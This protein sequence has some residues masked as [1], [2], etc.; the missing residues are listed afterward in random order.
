MEYSRLFQRTVLVLIT[1]TAFSILYG[2]FVV[3]VLEPPMP[4]NLQQ[5]P[6]SARPRMP[7]VSDPQYRGLFHE[8]D[9][10]Q[11]PDALLRLNRCHIFLRGISFSA[12]QIQGNECTIL[13][14]PKAN[15]ETEGTSISAPLLIHVPEGIELRFEPTDPNAMELGP[16][17]WAHIKGTIEGSCA[18]DPTTPNDDVT[19]SLK[20]VFYENGFISTDDEIDFTMGQMHCKGQGLRLPLNLGNLKNKDEA[21][22]SLPT[23]TA[24][25]FIEISKLECL[26]VLLTR[27]MLAASQQ[28]ARPS[29]TSATSSTS[30]ETNAATTPTA[31]GTNALAAQETT[32]RDSQSELPQSLEGLF[33]EDG[34]LPAG[35]RCQ[36]NVL[37]DLEQ[38]KM[39]FSENVHIYVH[40]GTGV[41]DSLDCDTLEI[42]FHQPQDWTESDHL[43]TE[44]TRTVANS[45]IAGTTS[46]EQTANTQTDSNLPQF[47][48]IPQQ[49]T[50]TGKTVTFQSN[51]FASS[52]RGN[53]LQIDLRNRR[54]HLEGT[55]ETELHIRNTACFSKSLDYD[56]PNDQNPLGRLTAP[57]N[58]WM[59]TEMLQN[60]QP[61]VVRLNWRGD[62]EAGPDPEDPGLYLL[63]LHSTTIDSENVGRLSAPS[64][65]VYLKKTAETTTN[66]P[67][68]N[69][70][71]S[72]SE[73]ADNV[74]FFRG[75]Q[76]HQLTA[77]DG[78]T[79]SCRYNGMD[80]E[81]TFKDVQINF[82]Q[83]SDLSTGMASPAL[84]TVPNT[85]PN[86]APNIG[87]PTQLGSPNAM[88][89]APQ[90]LLLSKFQI[91]AD[92]LKGNVQWTPTVPRI[93]SLKLRGNVT[94][95]EE[96]LTQ[97]TDSRVTIKADE[98]AL[99]N[100]TKTNFE[101][102]ASGN[103]T[104]FRGRGIRIQGKSF[105]L[106]SCMNQIW[107][108]SPGTLVV[109][110]SQ[111]QNIGL[112]APELSGDL[113]LT[114]G[115][116]NFNGLLLQ[117]SEKVSVTHPASTL[118]ADRIDLELASRF[119]LTN[120]DAWHA[121]RQMEKQ[122]L[123]DLFH[124]VTAV[125]SV[126]LFGQN[127]KNGKR[128]QLVRLNAGSLQYL[129]S[130]G[131]IRI[132]GSI[133]SQ[134]YFYE[135]KDTV[136]LDEAAPSSAFAPT[137]TPNPPTDQVAADAQQTPY[138]RRMDIKCNGPCT[139]NTN[140]GTY[141][142]LNGISLISDL[143]NDWSSSQEFR[144]DPA[145]LSENGYMLDAD[146][147]EFGGLAIS[148]T[149]KIDLQPNLNATGNIQLE[150]RRFSARAQRL[151][152]SFA[153]AQVILEGDSIPAHITLLPTAKKP[154]ANMKAKTIQLNT[155]T[156]T[157]RGEGI[158]MQDSY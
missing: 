52:A 79:F 158:S 90:S 33:H 132:A 96:T 120:P 103:P 131:D 110:E 38:K 69:Q 4:T 109:A 85:D 97:P 127:I 119:D 88:P 72:Q 141:Q 89:D 21:N 55:Q 58:G 62:L 130:T 5:M 147:L 66:S 124:S 37:L 149:Q 16:M 102:H 2:A 98:V 83:T 74:N 10:E 92:Q 117:L 18:G 128:T 75:Y 28:A 26:D 91:S 63:K 54:M 143:V 17:N 12:E 64:I 45:E 32:K 57:K 134:V 116:L 101:I 86:A 140:M 25:Q 137:T 29:T 100:L 129:P 113:V 121:L 14:Y 146:K 39:T 42:D 126:S 78:V 139:G 157:F 49:I 145:T 6:E 30:N 24:I 154:G 118:E 112:P 68:P 87:N 114:Y 153:K 115:K 73:S 106:N 41:S 60:N 105:N 11:N 27:E 9:W 34:T 135:K 125:G 104:E 95:V 111:L 94:I 142:L 56:F 51:K 8:G 152:A 65:L 156:M 133:F 148:Q 40:Y 84:S 50:A 81:G 76:L 46:A 53:L 107:A 123:L 19:F 3:P 136:S 44:E 43:H 23:T 59:Q 144:K 1:V 22:S 31:G 48:M 77:N 82:E 108:D 20:D 151:S 155:D 36:G 35:L 15:L 99:G 150:S 138:L 71:G 93:A 47:Q 122:K 7:I 61:M 80:T 70:P 67:V 13:Y